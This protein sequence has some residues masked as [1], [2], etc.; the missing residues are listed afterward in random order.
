[1]KALLEDHA[2]LVD[3]VITEEVPTPRV[4]NALLTPLQ[5]R[6]LLRAQQSV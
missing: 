1:M 5:H 3:L 4:D 2:R 6:L